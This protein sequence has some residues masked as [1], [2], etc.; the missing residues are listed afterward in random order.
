MMNSSFE[1]KKLKIN[2]GD[3][4]LAMTLNTAVPTT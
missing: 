3:Q 2:P 4:L 1:E